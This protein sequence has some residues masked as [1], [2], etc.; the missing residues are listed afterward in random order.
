[1]N[2]KQLAGIIS[3]IGVMMMTIFGC[4]SDSVNQFT[5]EQVISNALEEPEGLGTYYAE[6]AMTTKEQGVEAEKL[7]LKEWVSKEGKR[8]TETENADGSNV[9]IAV[10]DGTKLISYQPEINKAFVIESEDLFPLNNVS[11]KE[12]AEQLLK[13]TRDTHEVTLN[14]EEEIAGRMAYHIIA[15][16]EAENSLFGDQELWIDKENWFVLKIYSK[17]GNSEVEM[18]YTK[19]EFDADIADDI[20]ALQLPEDAEIENLEDINNTSEVTLAE[21][22]TSL[23]GEFLYF[24]EVEGL[25]ISNVELTRLQG[26]INRNEVAIDYEK[27]GLPAFMMSVFPTQEEFSEGEGFP[28]E[29]KTTVRDQKASYMEMNDFRMLNWQENDLTYSIILI[30]PTLTIDQLKERTETMIPVN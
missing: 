23:D 15:K 22:A 18:V 24:P 25:V 10:N 29:Q 20:F 21:A 5:P 30:D 7:V 1:M 26:E 4:S 28:G 14:G 6:A 11:P 13:L 3:L 17:S 19:I 2:F 9:N 16:A 8:R 27:D 12:Q